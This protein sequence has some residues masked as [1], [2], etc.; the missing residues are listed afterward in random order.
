M[1][2]LAWACAM[3]S[4]ARADLDDLKVRL[5]ADYTWDDNVNRGI[6]GQHLRDRF[7]GARI[8]LSLPL[9]LSERIRLMVTATGGGE[10]FDQY[11]GLDRAFAELQGELQYRTSGKFGAPIYGLFFRQAQDWYDSTLRDGYRSTIGLTLRKPATDKVFLFA[12]LGYNRRDGKSEVFDDEDYFVR[13]TLDYSLAQH[14]SIY[15]GLE[16]RYGDSVSSG[17]PALAPLNIAEAVVAD[18]AFPG[19]FAYKTKS[20]TGIVTVGY[21]FAFLQRH[22]LD[23]SYRGIYSRPKE[24]PPSNVSADDL[25]YIDNQFT[26]SYLL[27]F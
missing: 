25:Y 6:K 17:Q 1:A 27:R 11:T 4:P 18:D 16:Y 19:L 21:N 24:Q 3:S 14:H 8:G 2:A 13:G 12:S 7:A 15:V 26:V 5:S 20:H 9:N 10:K 22:A 23:F